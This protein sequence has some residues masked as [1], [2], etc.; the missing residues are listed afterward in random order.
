MATIHPTDLCRLDDGSLVNGYDAARTP[1][2]V[3]EVCGKPDVTRLLRSTVRRQ[4]ML[5]RELASIF[6][7]AGKAN[8]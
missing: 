8:P 7:A 2:R 6:C 1:E 4:Q 3:I 5:A